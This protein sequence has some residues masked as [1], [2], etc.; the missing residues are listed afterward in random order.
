MPK[1]VKS[2]AKKYRCRKH[3]AVSKKKSKNR[4]KKSRMYRNSEKVYVFCH[5]RLLLSKI[6]SARS[7]KVSDIGSRNSVPPITGT[8]SLRS[9]KRIKRAALIPIIQKAIFLI[10]DHLFLLVLFYIIF[11]ECYEYSCEKRKRWMVLFILY[12]C[13]AKKSEYNCNMC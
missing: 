6:S 10:C 8:T 12:K 13:I 4:Q 9:R 11:S 5:L 7:E 2:G 1:L 3:T